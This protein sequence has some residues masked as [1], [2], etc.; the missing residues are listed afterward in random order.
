MA[1][2]AIDGLNIASLTENVKEYAAKAV[3]SG[4]L[5]REGD[6][7][8]TKILVCPMKEDDRLFEVSERLREGY[9]E[10]EAREAAGK[11]AALIK[12]T[13]PK[14]LLG[15]WEYANALASMQSVNLVE[16][17]L[18]EQGILI[19]PKDGIGAEGCWMSVYKPEENE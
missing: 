4:F 11:L 2:R 9:F 7:L 6:R 12:K 10:E 18:I 8:Y 16:N 5:Y 17:A 15:E 1:L 3:Q 14:H 13:V 19:P